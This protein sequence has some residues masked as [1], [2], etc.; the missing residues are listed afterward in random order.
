MPLDGPI[1]N[2]T[3][4]LTGPVQQQ[5]EANA[6]VTSMLLQGLLPASEYSLSVVA[7]N[8]YGTGNVTS[9]VVTTKNPIGECLQI[10]KTYMY[11]N[12][13]MYI[14]HVAMCKKSVYVR[15]HQCIFLSFPCIFS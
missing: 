10:L 1:L 2:Y 15:G 3:A 12:L 5:K 7:S 6:S 4:V 13:Y 8:V 14:V 11:K 9:V